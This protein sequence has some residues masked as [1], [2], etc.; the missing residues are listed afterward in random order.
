ML[1]KQAKAVPGQAMTVQGAHA[2]AGR[3]LDKVTPRF[4]GELDV[5]PTVLLRAALEEAE[6]Q[7]RK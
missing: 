1:E 5:D 6:A 2:E 3:I 7:Q 4:K